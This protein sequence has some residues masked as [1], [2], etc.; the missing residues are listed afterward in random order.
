SEAGNTLDPEHRRRHQGKPEP[1]RRKKTGRLPAEPRSGDETRDG[2]E[3][4]DPAESEG[5]RRESVVAVHAAGEVKDH[6]GR[7]AKG[8]GPVGCVAAVFG[9]PVWEIT[10][11]PRPESPR[12]A[13]TGASATM[14]F[15]GGAGEDRAHGSSLSSTTTAAG[16]MPKRSMSSL[17]M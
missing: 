5:D 14:A 8:D 4:P 3:S 11:T 9:R 10:L 7:L 17:S 13:L 6:A 15:C 16:S 2:G 1:R 12:G